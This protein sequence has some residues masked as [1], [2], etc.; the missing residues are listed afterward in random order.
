MQVEKSYP[1]NIDRIDAVLKVKGRKGIIFTYGRTI[2]N[3]HGSELTPYLMAHEEVHADQQGMFPDNWWHRY[4]NDPAF[5]LD[6]E[7]MAHGVEVR[8]YCE[9]N[10]RG[11]RRHYVSEAAKRISGI[12]YGRIITFADAHRMFK[13]IMADVVRERHGGG[14]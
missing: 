9:V 7:L 2:Y 1:P 11:Q 6:Q 3:P 10:G 14:L 12:A 4:L 13:E 8:K 5:R